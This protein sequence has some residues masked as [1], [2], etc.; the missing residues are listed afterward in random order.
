MYLKQ[1]HLI[2]FFLYFGVMFLGAAFTPV[3]VNGFDCEMYTNYCRKNTI[4]T[5]F[6]NTCLI[7]K[8]LHNLV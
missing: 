8:P 4:C 6:L 5:I 1:F 3:I 7:L 2:F